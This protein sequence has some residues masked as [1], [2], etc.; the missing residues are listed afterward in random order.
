MFHI[1]RVH[2]IHPLKFRLN[3]TGKFISHKCKIK[4]HSDT[5]SLVINSNYQGMIF[6][7]FTLNARYFARNRFP[8]KAPPHN[9]HNQASTTVEVSCQ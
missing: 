1:S 6:T 3:H 7:F 9:D 2:V 4:I 8:V 5:A